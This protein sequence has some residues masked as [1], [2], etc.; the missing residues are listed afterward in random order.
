MN[1]NKKAIK[2]KLGHGDL[3]AIA[4]KLGISENTVYNAFNG[5]TRKIRM[6]VAEAA[7]ELI[8]K[9]EVTAKKFAS[10]IE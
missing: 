3:R 6:D 7:L 5:K 10:I 2:S 4:V 8:E 1:V 9:R